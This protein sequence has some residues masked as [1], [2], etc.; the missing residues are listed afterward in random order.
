MKRAGQ[1]APAAAAAEAVKT[2][3]RSHGKEIAEDGELLALLL[4]ERFG[5]ATNVRDLQDFVI[6][7]LVV[8]NSG[9]K[10]ERDGLR[11]VSDRAALMREGVRKLVL[12]IIAA[13]SFEETIAVATNAANALGADLVTLGVESSEPL[14]LPAGIQG[15]RLLPCGLADSLIGCDAIGAV[16]KGGG[17]HEPLFAGVLGGLQS[18]AIFRMQLGPGAPPALYAVGANL[19]ERFDDES[20]TREIAHFVRALER[21]I[22]AWLDLPRS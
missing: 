11:R 6:E 17:G 2:F 21:A 4:P 19:P 9:L 7:K 16:L 15:L 8:E 3:L 10:A 1:L 12:D 5:A 13:R 18:V 20:E 14:Q 22:A